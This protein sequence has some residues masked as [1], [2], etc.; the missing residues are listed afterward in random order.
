MG[1]AFK[2]LLECIEL[3][4]PG[5]FDGAPAL[6]VF[7]HFNFLNYATISFVI[8]SAIMW[9][10]SIWHDARGGA[11]PRKDVSAFLWRRT[12][13]DRLMEHSLYSPATS[14]GL[15]PDEEDGGAGELAL[16]PRRK[17]EAEDVTLFNSGASEGSSTGK[18]MGSERRGRGAGRGSRKRAGGAH[19]ENGASAAGR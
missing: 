14:P 12:L 1:G 18:G 8:C 3:A 13:Y 11:S 19:R 6:A 16:T 10:A 5:M 17:N 4:N 7:V 15:S 9:L 2:F